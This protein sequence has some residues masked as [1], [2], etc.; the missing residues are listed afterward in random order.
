MSVQVTTQETLPLVSQII[1]AGTTV[2]ISFPNQFFGIAED[3]RL[4]NLDG[5]NNATF[6]INGESQPVN[7]I[8]P[9]A[10]MP[11]GGTKITLITITA[12]AAAAVQLEANIRRLV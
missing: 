10:V 11:F 6:Q 5:A 3:V 8:L 4:T 7:T 1:P 12:G 2:T 9:S